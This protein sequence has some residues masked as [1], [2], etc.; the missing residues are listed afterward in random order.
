M[1][2]KNDLKMIYREN[3]GYIW[4]AGILLILLLM[5]SPASAFSGSGAGTSGDPYQIT[6]P[7]QW[8]EIGSA[9]SSY[10]QLQNDIDFSGVTYTGIQ[11]FTGTLNG[12]NYMVK[13]AA[14]TGSILYSEGVG[15]F[16]TCEGAT[17]TNMSVVNITISGSDSQGY[18]CAGFLVG[19]CLGSNANTFSNL[20]I[21][22]SSNTYGSS[23]PSQINKGSLFGKSVAQT[24]NVI[25]N[26]I[27]VR[28]TLATGGGTEGSTQ[29]IGGLTG[30]NG[31]VPST[32]TY[33][34]VAVTQASSAYP[35]GYNIGSGN[36]VYYDNTLSTH[37]V[38]DS[39]AALTTSQ[40]GTLTSY[41]TWTQS[42]YHIWQGYPVQNAL[43]VTIPV[44]AFTLSPSSLYPAAPNLTLTDASTG[45]AP[46]S[47][48]VWWGDGTSTVLG[49]PWGVGYSVTHS[50]S[51]PT[52][53]TT[54]TITYKAGNS[55][56]NDSNVT[57]TRVFY[58]A[59]F[60]AWN[61]DQTDLS[62]TLR[63]LTLGQSLTITDA[64]TNMP[65]AWNFTWGTTPATYAT[66]LP[67]TVTYTLVSAKTVS[68]TVSNP[69][70][71]STRA[72]AGYKT[73]TVYGV[74][75]FTVYTQTPT[76][77]NFNVG[78]YITMAGTA[79]VAA[80]AY[81]WDM[82][83]ARANVSALSSGN[84][85]FNV[86]GTF[87]PTL[88]YQNYGNNA[89]YYP[90]YTLANPIT[91][92]GAFT[93]TLTANVT[94]GNQPL[95]VHFEDT[96]TD[97][98]WVS[99][100]WNFG[101]GTDTGKIV[102]HTY[103]NPGTY[104]VTM[105]HTQS[106]GNSGVASTTITVN[107]IQAPVALWT[108][109]V[110]T[111][112]APFTVQFTDQATGNPIS[113]S[114]DFGDSTTSTL[115]NPTHTY[116]TYTAGTPIQRT[117]R[118]TVYSGLGDSTLAKIIT[119]TEPAPTASF[120][121][122]ADNG[123]IPWTMTFTD[124]STGN[125]TAWSYNFGDGTPP[126]ILVRNP[127]HTYYAGGI[128]NVT[129]YATNT[130][131][132]TSQTQTV[133]I[134]P[135][136]G[137]GGTPGGVPETTT[138]SPLGGKII[139]TPD[140]VVFG[141]N[142]TVYYNT[143]YPAYITSAKDGKSY[144]ITGWLLTWYISDPTDPTNTYFYE[145]SGYPIAVQSNVATNFTGMNEATVYKFQ[146]SV[147]NGW[148]GVNFWSLLATNV[149]APNE[150]FGVGH[151]LTCQTAQNMTF[152]NPT[153]TPTWANNLP[154]PKPGDSITF[155]WD[156]KSF[157][158][159]KGQPYHFL[160]LQTSTD[161]GVTWVTPSSFPMRIDNAVTDSVTVTTTQP[162]LIRTWIRAQS[163]LVDV[164]HG[165]DLN[166]P[167][168]QL[169]VSDPTV[170]PSFVWTNDAGQTITKALDTDTIRFGFS[171]GNA[172]EN[173]NYNQ[174]ALVFYKYNEQTK[175][176]DKVD[177]TKTPGF[178]ESPTTG[179]VAS[180]DTDATH[181]WGRYEMAGSGRFAISSLPSPTIGKYRVDIV[182][183]NT[184]G[185]TY[186][187]AVLKT[188]DAITITANALNPSNLANGAGGW[189]GIDASGGVA[190][191][192]AGIIISLIIGI[193]LFY[194]VRDARVFLVGL[195][196]GAVLS[197]TIG[198]FDAWIL[199]ILGIIGVVILLFSFGILG[200]GGGEYRGGGGNGGTSSAETNY[201]VERT[202]DKYI[203]SR[204]GD[205]KDTEKFLN[206]GGYD[207]Q[208]SK[209]KGL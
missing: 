76:G 64:S 47:G 81:L 203:A 189:F 149:T 132:T 147:M 35:I 93:P 134:Q 84:V 176:W 48:Q 66:S 77:Q 168:N 68:L 160:Y 200:T 7:A 152:V 146:P 83:G 23:A 192:A 9:S 4:L 145:K 21:S 5:T 179:H 128:Y 182:G 142:N 109:N 44:S 99:T 97:A 126:T 71:S 60:A 42:N 157:R 80:K 209:G 117:V 19:R 74:P 52:N 39:E 137:T 148:N 169:E 107:A 22:D 143:T 94:S 87:A 78:D 26:V 173:E 115:Q 205:V 174:I 95:T 127:T 158:G 163:A 67:A 196:G 112:Q 165:D 131:G 82:K 61:D 30:N 63:R 105:T 92:S 118:E 198:L 155:T 123:E 116:T 15:L 161:G 204:Q 56:G 36:T 89:S 186:Y 151:I 49:S 98:S 62:S 177:T 183:S 154:N 185:I 43:H 184:N 24:A 54:Y 79:P 65:T 164:T 57:D 178:V 17:F 108:S 55:A 96:T 10:Y 181:A 50:Y 20:Y 193:V 120:T 104:S 58:R 75:T 206:N 53:S 31:Y 195:A 110:T 16:D 139:G 172:W 162:E 135:T 2:L 3:S 180:A 167:Y 141:Y 18:V 101:D 69:A 106:G 130:G 121:H 29:F 124:T 73:Y 119:V 208:L 41:T 8:L 27:A 14:F 114:W 197:F 33:C 194:F 85:Q 138:P 25:T 45:G 102:D 111:G 86:A 11:T 190:R 201:K 153:I 38:V 175:L 125:P 202:V 32:F 13:N 187:T 59:P 51:S 166:T 40:A 12:R 34:L 191:Y 207:G 100:A 159:V 150:G 122:S 133:T 199:L 88:Y 6:T 140:P 91:V 156:E 188:S 90:M 103:V 136:T 70:G 46:T 28:N 144:R 1:T 170:N 129:M 72:G 113:W 37:A 171:S